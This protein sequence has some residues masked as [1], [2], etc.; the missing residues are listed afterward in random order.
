MAS[1]EVRLEELGFT[2]PDPPGA[3]AMYRPALQSG[4]YVFVSGQVAMRDGAIVHPGT[5]G[6]QQTVE[7]AREA[8]QVATLNALAAVKALRGSLEGLRVCGSPG[9]SR[10]LRT[11][12]STR[13]W[14]NAASE[15]LRDAFGEEAG[16]GTRLALGVSSLPLQSP[17]ELALELEVVDGDPRG[18]PA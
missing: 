10:P 4:P 2:L 11:S 15:L 6:A 5:V 17:V 8:A 7:T 1:V 14:I 16:V 12:G 18:I 9:T 13:R 3:L